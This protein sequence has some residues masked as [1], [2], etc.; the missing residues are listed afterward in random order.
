MTTCYLK[1]VECQQNESFCDIISGI[2]GQRQNDV[3]TSY[4][5]SLC[6]KLTQF[7]SQNKYF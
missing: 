1:T 4:Q 5:T 2:I 7:V 6:F 3:I